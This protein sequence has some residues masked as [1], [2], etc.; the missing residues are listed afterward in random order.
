MA[1]NLLPPHTEFDLLVELTSAR[2]DIHALLD[3]ALLLSED[4][5]QLQEV[6]TFTLRPVSLTLLPLRPVSI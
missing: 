4:L 5:F 1:S 3:E 6:R 2:D